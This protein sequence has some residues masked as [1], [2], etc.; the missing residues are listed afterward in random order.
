VSRIGP[1][2]PERAKHADLGDRAQAGE[3]RCPS[4]HKPVGW[5]RVEDGAVLV[6]EVE[7]MPLNPAEAR[8]FSRELGEDVAEGATFRGTFWRTVDRATM[9]RFACRPRC[10]PLEL[11]GTA[12]AAAGWRGRKV[13]AQR[14]ASE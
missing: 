4:C 5:L 3:V 6:S 2:E 7:Q 12:L 11:D 13:R 1:A 8:I 10:G 9:Y 14:C